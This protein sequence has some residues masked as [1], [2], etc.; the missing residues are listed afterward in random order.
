MLQ[1]LELL[2]KALHALNWLA[3]QLSGNAMVSM[4]VVTLCW[5]RLVPGVPGRVTVFGRV[6]YAVCYQPPRLSQLGHPSVGRRNESQ[7]RLKR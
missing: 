4:N 6:I 2:V 1:E 3:V 5:D 7:L